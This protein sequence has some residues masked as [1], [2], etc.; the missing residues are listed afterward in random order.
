MQEQTPLTTQGR[1]GREPGD[2]KYRMS[3]DTLMLIRKIGSIIVNSPSPPPEGDAGQGLVHRVTRDIE[4]KSGVR[5]PVTARKRLITVEKIAGPAVHDGEE[6]FEDSKRRKPQ[7]LDVTD[8]MAESGETDPVPRPRSPNIHSIEIK[9][10][11][12]PKEVFSKSDSTVK[13]EGEK[14]GTCPS[15]KPPSRHA[16]EK[17]V[18]IEEKLEVVPAKS[19]K[20][21]GVSAKV[22]NT[23]ETSSVS[24]GAAA[25]TSS[26]ESE[27]ERREPSWDDVKVRELV[28][29]FESKDEVQASPIASSATT[30]DTMSDFGLTFQTKATKAKTCDNK[31]RVNLTKTRTKRHTWTAGDKSSG[32]DSSGSATKMAKRQSHRETKSATRGK[33]QLAAGSEEPK[34]SAAH[35]RK[36]SPS[37]GCAG[38]DSVKSGRSPDGSTRT[39]GTGKQSTRVTEGKKPKT[40]TGTGQSKPRGAGAGPT[41]RTR[42]ISEPP[43]K[44]V[45]GRNTT[46]GTERSDKQTVD[47]KTSLPSKVSGDRSS[48]SDGAKSRDVAPGRSALLRKKK[49]GSQTESATTRSPSAHELKPQSPQ[50]SPG[51]ERSNKI[52]I[53]MSKSNPLH[54]GGDSPAG[55]CSPPA[56]GSQL[57]PVGSPSGARLAG[58]SPPSPSVQRPSPP[59][60]GRGSV[61]ISVGKQTH[62]KT[63]PL[64]RLQGQE[65][66]PGRGPGRSPNPFYNTM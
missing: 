59:G 35:A 50:G 23:L 2:P 7:F 8:N 15:P 65:P 18:I 5:M 6:A 14:R 20:E 52:P 53:G 33:S 12:I 21:P 64:A 31:D 26:S 43:G 27:S 9:S 48:D 25:G 22:Q 29:I 19:G 4:L 63:H 47:R 42:T 13:S 44:G 40:T 41:S 61:H 60:L 51:T 30:Q 62:G 66:P 24:S 58:T 28:G 49:P 1:H 54:I 36:V 3:N 57:S 39:S 46:A 17:K 16:T 45:K 55:G 32:S 11:A 10:I 56:A 38:K 34:S 37:N